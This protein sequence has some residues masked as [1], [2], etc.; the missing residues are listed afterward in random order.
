MYIKVRAKTGMKKEELTEI[1]EAHFTISV[2]EKPVQ[3]LANKRIIALI[4]KHFRVPIGKV[5]ILNGRHSPSKL[6]SVDI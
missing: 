6:L 4:A 1:S 5:R 2:R 3:N